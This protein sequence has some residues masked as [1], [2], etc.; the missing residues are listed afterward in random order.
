M[1]VTSKYKPPLGL[2]ASWHTRAAVA[3][4]Y[5]AEAIFSMVSIEHTMRVRDV[6][7]DCGPK[8]GAYLLCKSW[9][10]SLVTS[11][12]ALISTI[13]L[14][15]RPPSTPTAPNNIAHRRLGLERAT[16]SIRTMVVSTCSRCP[17][18]RH[19]IFVV[20]LS[21]DGEDEWYRSGDIAP[22]TDPG[23]ASPI[24]FWSPVPVDGHPIHPSQFPSVQKHRPA[25]VTS[26]DLDSS[27]QSLS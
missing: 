13:R 16:E 10:M 6:R 11:E 23:Y 18:L 25:S 22:V 4:V 26:A 27:D 2:Q 9:L 20:K 14:G 7:R 5:Y 3:K 8:D 12:R 21:T 24:P 1:H 19:G 17:V 15:C